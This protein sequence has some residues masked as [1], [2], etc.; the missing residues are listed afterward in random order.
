M[1]LQKTNLDSPTMRCTENT[2]KFTEHPR[3]SMTST[4]LHSNS[5]EIAPLQGNHSTNSPLTFSK[6]H[7]GLLLKRESYLRKKFIYTS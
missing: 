1:P 2:Q 4:K 5:I 7:E 3:R 6:T